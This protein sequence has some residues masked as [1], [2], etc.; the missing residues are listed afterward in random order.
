MFLGFHSS[1]EAEAGLRLVCVDGGFWYIPMV[2]VLH[3]G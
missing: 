1:F 2:T 3:V